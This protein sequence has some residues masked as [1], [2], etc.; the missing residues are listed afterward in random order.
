VAA[1]AGA[2][3]A[4][5]LVLLHQ[6]PLSGRMFDRLLPLLA[7]RRAVI[8]VDTPGYGESDRPSTQPTLA[9]YGDAIAETLGKHHEP[10]FD[11]LGYHTGAVIAADIAARRPA[12]VRRLVLVSIPYFDDGRRNALLKQL[13][14][15]AGYAEDGSHLL[16]LWTGSFRVKPQGQSLDDVARLVAEKQ[17]VGQFGEWALAAAMAADMT[18]ML[19]AIR[20]PSL[21]IAPHDGLEKESRA[22]AGL[23]RHGRL[24]ELPARGYGLFDAAAAEIAKLVTAFLDSQPA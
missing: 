14:T 8:A 17:R 22:A 6:S 19:R 20:H 5:P 16:P 3:T 24:T 12:E 18:P 1:P 21:V 4:P 10:P 13:A 7:T 9:A 15:K 11:L 2:P 23:L